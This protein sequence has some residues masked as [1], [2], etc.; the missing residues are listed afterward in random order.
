MKKLLALLL[1]ALMVVSLCACKGDKND[2]EEDLNEYLNKEEVADSFTDADGNVFYFELINSDSV[3]IV[4]YTGKDAPHAITIPDRVVLNPYDPEDQ[5]EYANVVA[6]ANQ[7][8]YY[9]SNINAVTLPATVTE[10]GKYAF[11][12]CSMLTSITLPATVTTVGEGAFSRCSLLAS[13][14]FAEGSTV[15]K[16]ADKLFFDCPA[17]QTVTLPATVTSIGTGAFHGCAALSAISIP[18][19]VTAISDQAFQNCA[20]LASVTLADTSGLVKI[21]S[22]AFAGCKLLESFTVTAKVKEIGQ[23]AFSGCAA[24]N[25]VS[26][27]NTDLW[28]TYDPAKVTENTVLIETEPVS[29][30]LITDPAQAA[31]TVNSTHCTLSWLYGNQDGE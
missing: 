27:K 10:I 16:I 29:A 19:S 8:F 5:W 21:G 2:T 31:T 20:A 30:D 3:Q 6:L 18:D 25:S 7:A 11:A 26:F 28:G 9:Q 23:Y 15:E 24:L 13:A 14:T 4:R 12:G 22:F 1:A 17:L